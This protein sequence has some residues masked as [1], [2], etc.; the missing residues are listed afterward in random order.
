MRPSRTLPL[1]LSLAV[2]RKSGATA[3][4]TT[5]GAACASA[6]RW[7]AALVSVV[8][9]FVPQ[10][11]RAQPVDTLERQWERVSF[12]T[13]PLIWASY[14]LATSWGEVWVIDTGERAVFRWSATGEELPRVGG[15]GAGPGEYYRPSL[16]IEMDGDSVSVWDR[17]QQ[18]VSFFGRDGKF[19]SVRIIPL[20]MG[21]HGFGTAMSLRGDTVLA[22]ASINVGVE[23]HPRDNQAVLWRFVGAD[24]RADSLLAMR[25]ESVVTVRHDAGLTRFRAPYNGRAYAF[26]QDDGS[27]VLGHGEDSALSVLD[28]RGREIRRVEL[29]LPPPLALT[30]A[31]REHFS[32]SLRLGLEAERASRLA[33]APAAALA[34][35]QESDRRWLRNLDFPD[36]HPRYTDAFQDAA[37]TLWLRMAA[38]LLAELVEWRAYDHM[39]GDHLRSVFL[40]NDAF[41]DTRTADGSAFFV[42]VADEI[43]QSRLVKYGR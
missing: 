37:G 9:A 23:P 31:Y 34:A 12:D 30:R 18:R 33:G 41:L 26:F 2:R 6:L 5:P 42:T 43:G 11:S 1:A 28:E 4:L 16:L 39:T 20:A 24:L 27:V 8:A 15:L 36:Y 40:P 38:P 32:D 3:K 29:D 21:A 22:L 19:L 10:P 17:S 14:L 7:V 35:L 25:D 13:L